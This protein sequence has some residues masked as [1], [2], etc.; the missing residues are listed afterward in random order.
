MAMECE[1]FFDSSGEYASINTNC[2]HSP[3][4][5]SDL[6]YVAAF[7]N[8]NLFMFL[9]N[10]FFG[11][12]RMSG[13]YYQFQSP[14]LRVIPLRNLPDAE[15]ER[16]VELVDSIQSDSHSDERA[17]A[18]AL[19]EINAV[20]YRGYSLSREEIGIIERVQ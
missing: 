6:Q 2:F 13:G 19:A 5:A 4:N 15:R 1:A 12:L 16:L 14:Q 18:D 3:L 17:K 11:A 7:C 20:I 8:S 10:Q 9:Y